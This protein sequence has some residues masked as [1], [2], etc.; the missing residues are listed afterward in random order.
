MIKT[1]IIIFNALTVCLFSIFF[2]DTPVEVTGNFPK[3]V[4]PSSDFVAEIKI[5][6]GS[7]TGFA[8]L[9][10]DIPQGFSVKELESKSGN[11]SFSNN[12]AKIIWTAL[13]SE[14]E[15]IVKF[16]ISTDATAS[17]NKTI[18]SKFSYIN[19]NLKLV[20]EMQPAEI[21]IG[22]TSNLNPISSKEGDSQIPNFTETK[23]VNPSFENPSNPNPTINCTRKITA[24]QT[25]NTFNVEVKIEKESV[26]GFAKYQEVLPKGYTAKANQT[27]GSS[28]SITD[29]KLKF[30]WVSLPLDY[31][32]NISYTL[33]K[34]DAAT[35]NSKLI[36][37]E[38]SYLVED[39]TKKVTMPIELI[40]NASDNVERIVSTPPAPKTIPPVEEVKQPNKIKEEGPTMVEQP[41]PVEPLAVAESKK[42]IPVKTESTKTV[43]IENVIAKKEGNVLFNVQVGAFQNAI[44]ASV[45]SK[46]FNLSDPIKSEMSEGFSK[47]MVGN[48]SEYKLA[49]NHRETIKQK[50]CN[51]AFVVAYNGPKRITVQEALM[52]ANQKWFK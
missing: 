27:N 1:A 7:I 14:A 4:A 16:T 13:P 39:Q 40:E 11:F 25:S 17:G 37:G 35:T 15:Y 41:T 31:E 48:F 6:K 36:G 33:E 50:G 9:Q 49:R 38:F 45:L 28:F 34:T 26:V 42:E 20:A 19:N 43:T 51:S 10:L 32:L 5:V 8:K 2:G 52:I 24:G 22:T 23:T 47:F 21:Q 30:V 46:K 44:K 3:N 29:N 12:I 18:T